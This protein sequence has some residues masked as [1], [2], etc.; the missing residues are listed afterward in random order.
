MARLDF[1]W[2]SFDEPDSAGQALILGGRFAAVL[3]DTAVRLKRRYVTGSSDRL[4]V[5][6]HTCMTHLRT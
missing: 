6:A 5:L 2:R 3:P 4:C 1:P